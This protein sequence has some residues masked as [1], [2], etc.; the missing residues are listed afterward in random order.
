MVIVGIVRRGNV[1]GN[2]GVVCESNL[3]DISTHCA[4]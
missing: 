4:Y 2:M 3:D 1:G